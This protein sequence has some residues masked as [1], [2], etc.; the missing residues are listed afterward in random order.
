MTARHAR[1]ISAPTL[2]AHTPD[3]VLLASIA[4]GDLSA[5]AAIYDR[6]HADVFRFVA[7]IARRRDAVDDIVQATFILLPKVAK[8]FDGRDSAR[9]WLFGIALRLEA[10]ER[11]TAARLARMLASFG[12]I[13]RG[14][15]T[16][17]P[18]HAAMGREEAAVFK[19]AFDRL[20]DKKREVFLLLEV[21]GITAEEASQVL[22]VPAATVRTR[23][24]NA[25]KELREAMKREGAW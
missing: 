8:S 4:A 6:Y 11:R 21:E 17:D 22:G 2:A 9:A 20:S 1:T 15:G 12:G 25:K 19:V 13:L 23:L 5:L 18:E 14:W 10:R 7:R 3:P 24:F 16:P